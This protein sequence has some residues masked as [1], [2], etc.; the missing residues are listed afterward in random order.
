[1]GNF[2]STIKKVNFEDIQFICK[3]TCHINTSSIIIN[4]LDIFEQKCLIKGTISAQDEEKIIN[5]YINKKQFDTYI[6]VYGKNCNDD[7]G[8]IS[9]KYTQ[10]KKFG[11]TNIYIYLGGLFEWLLLQDIYGNDEFPTTT[12]EHDILKYKTSSLM[13]NHKYI[14]S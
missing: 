10:L 8:K 9:K 11:F 2:F 5:L 12:K 4:T 13:N 6:I 14:A 7:D 1:M 3:N